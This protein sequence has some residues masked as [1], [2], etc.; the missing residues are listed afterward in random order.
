MIR[1]QIHKIH[2]SGIGGSAASGVARY[3]KSQGFTISGSDLVCTKITRALEKAGIKIACNQRP[4]NV[5]NCD[6]LLL[7]AAVLYRDQHNPEIEQAKKSKI[8]I[9]TWQEFLPEYLEN[10]GK[11]GIM[12]AGAGGKGSTA[13]MIAEIMIKAG[14][15]PLCL[16]GAENINWDANFYLGRGDYYIMEADEFNR[17]FLNYHPTLALITSM[18]YEHPETYRNFQEYQTAF[19]EFVKNIKDRPRRDKLCQDMSRAVPAAMFAFY[20]PSMLNF[21]KNYLKNYPGKIFT[22]GENLNADLQLIDLEQTIA[23]LSFKIKNFNSQ[24]FILQSPC[25]YAAL[26]ALGAIALTKQIGVKTK[27]IAQALSEYQGLRRRFEI[28]EKKSITLIFDYAHAP[29]TI[30]TTLSEARRLFAKRRI[31]AVFQ[32]HLYS[33]TFKF[34]EEFAKSFSSADQVV[35]MDI[36]PSREQG[37][38]KEKLV[39]SKNLAEKLKIQHQQ[40]KYLPGKMSRT[41]DYLKKNARQQ[42]VIIM[43]GAGDICEIY[44]WL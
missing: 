44:N 41:A 33:R 7:S 42:D 12:T 34:L 32:P 29:K 14:L 26:N 43:L 13:S 37:T 25:R 21:I 3:L 28:K 20:E 5:K 27:I 31:I 4:E 10:Q 38:D 30:Q 24:K 40:V 39:S 8:P 19:A 16:L 17:N 36:F 18:I 11:I 35:L 1:A 2:F 15:D 9:K 23:G 6:L 22:Y